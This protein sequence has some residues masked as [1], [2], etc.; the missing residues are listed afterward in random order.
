MTLKVGFDEHI[1][2]FD[3]D[4]RKGTCTKIHMC[5]KHTCLI[6]DMKEYL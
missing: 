1:I 3:V 6:T 2:K 5:L 4:T